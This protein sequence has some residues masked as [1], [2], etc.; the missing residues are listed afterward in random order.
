MLYYDVDGNGVIDVI[1][2]ILDVATTGPNGLY[3]F[4]NLPPG[5][6]LA[7]AEEQQVP[8]PPSS[9]VSGTL[10][11]MVSTTGTEAPVNLAAGQAYLA[12][13]FGF[14]EAAEVKGSVFHD[15]DS[16]G[17]KSP[18]EPG[19]PSIT[20]VLTGTDINNNPVS[21]VYTTTATGA[22]EFI[23]PPGT[24]TITYDTADPQIPADL[25]AETTP[26]QPAGQPPR[27]PGIDRPRL[28]PRQ[29]GQGR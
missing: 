2:P 9:A 10:G 22:Y 19:L 24:Y 11:V 16:N 13:D 21:L 25:T 14:I 20:V 29:S 6:Y 12:A 1:D 18:S 26:T 17:V 23:V 7:K 8:A 4:D 5:T 27:G 15:V 3:L 28:W